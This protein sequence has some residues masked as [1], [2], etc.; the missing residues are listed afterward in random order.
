VNT[1]DYLVLDKLSDFLHFWIFFFKPGAV[2]NRT[3]V[4][5]GI[6]IGRKNQELN[7]PEITVRAI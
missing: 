3:C 5:W 1:Q 6:Q 7:S 4:A 2:P